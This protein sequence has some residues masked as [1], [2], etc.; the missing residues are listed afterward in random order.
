M[1]SDNLV[2][3]AI[4]AINLPQ[5]LVLQQQPRQVVGSVRDRQHLDILRMQYLRRKRNVIRFSHLRRTM[6]KISPQEE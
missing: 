5:P 1:A 2:V 4:P 3:E 6:E